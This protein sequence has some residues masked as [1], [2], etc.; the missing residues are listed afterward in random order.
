MI[1]VIV[2]ISVLAVALG[3][4]AIGAFLGERAEIRESLRRLEGYQ[5]TGARDQEMLKGFG[6]RV[7]DPLSTGALSLIKKYTPVGYTDN[8]RHKLVL[9]GNPPGFEVDRLLILKV[10]GMT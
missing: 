1:S 9:A 4:F 10:L 8:V 6:S 5:V 7:V 3:V 2:A